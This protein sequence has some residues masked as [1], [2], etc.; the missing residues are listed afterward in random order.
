MRVF[1]T[2]R[3]N[4]SLSTCTT[5]CLILLYSKDTK[6]MK[7]QRGGEKNKRLITMS[8]KAKICFLLSVQKNN[9]ENANSSQNESC[10]T[11]PLCFL[12]LSVSSS[13]HGGRRTGYTCLWALLQGS[14]LS[15]Q[16]FFM[17][18]IC[19]HSLFVEILL[20][21]GLKGSFQI[22]W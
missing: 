1:V 14:D 4:T 12:V 5:A 17:A 6:R 3:G 21:R 22:L 20:G 18:E 19:Q 9:P 7:M 16:L 8:V 2:G 10:F 13:H 11:V 15:F